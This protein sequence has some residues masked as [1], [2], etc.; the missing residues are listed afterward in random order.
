LASLT[1]ATALYAAL[2]FFLAPYLL[3]KNLVSA[4]KQEFDAQLRIE[5]I[6]VK[7]FILSLRIRE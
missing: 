6:E 4:M 1:C 7:P 2:G 5:K 3:E